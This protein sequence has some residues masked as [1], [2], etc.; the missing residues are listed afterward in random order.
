MHVMITII[1]WENSDYTSQPKR[2][3][4]PQNKVVL[5]SSCDKLVILAHQILSKGN[6]IGLDLFCIGFEP[7]CHGLLE[8][9]SESTNL[10]IMRT[11]LKRGENRKV[12]LVFKIIFCTLWLALLRWL[13]PLPVKD[14]TSPRSPQALVG[15]GCDNVTELKWI[16]SFLHKNRVR[17][18]STVRR[19]R[20]QYQ[21]HNIPKTN[22]N[23][24]QE[25]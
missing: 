17:T 2:P 4:I 14:H 11:T 7:R 15:C 23:D 10:V 1:D 13:R 18:Q 20:W 9:N 16:C 12:D 19:S 6:S 21:T 22:S 5:G 8:S 25:Y 3:E 24:T